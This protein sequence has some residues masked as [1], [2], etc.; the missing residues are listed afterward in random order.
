MIEFSESRLNLEQE[1]RCGPAS[2]SGADLDVRGG[3]G[4]LFDRVDRGG[5]DGGE[6]DDDGAV[7]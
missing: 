2:S 3:F 6:I 5:G 4:L 7:L 1:V